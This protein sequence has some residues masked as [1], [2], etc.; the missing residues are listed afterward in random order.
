MYK[1]V[2][3]DRKEQEEF[4]KKFG[5]Y[6]FAPPNLKEI[7][8]AEFFRALDFS[9]VAVSHK[10]IMESYDPS[11]KGYMNL[12]MFIFSDGSGVGY[13]NDWQY[14]KTPE[15]KQTFYKF[16]VCEHEYKCTLSRMCYSE[17]LCTKCGHT[18]AV[19]SSD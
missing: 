14:G 11:I 7:S 15:W 6:N 5:R 9:P 3:A 19:D 13:T 18:Y 16:A 4:E 2:Y 10:Q 8:Q 1:L 17:Y 12:H